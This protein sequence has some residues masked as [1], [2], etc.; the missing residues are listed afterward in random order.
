MRSSARTG[1]VTLMPKASSDSAN[2]KSMSRK[3][4]RERPSRFRD[5]KLRAEYREK[6]LSEYDGI[7]SDERRGVVNLKPGLHYETEF[8]SKQ[9]ELFDPE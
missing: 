5:G 6:V 2:G 1:S 8:S 3:A 9:R 7:W 4:Y